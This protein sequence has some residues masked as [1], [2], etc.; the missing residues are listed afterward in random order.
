M[1][2]L[3][4]DSRQTPNVCLIARWLLPRRVPAWISDWP[5][6]TLSRNLY[7]NHSNQT[8]AGMATWFTFLHSDDLLDW[9]KRTFFFGPRVMVLDPEP[10]HLNL[11]LP[12]REE[13][14]TESRWPQGLI[15]GCFLIARDHLF[16]MLWPMRLGLHTIQRVGTDRQPRSESFDLGGRQR[17]EG[18]SL[19][20][21][22]ARMC[23]P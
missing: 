19:D 23:F 15:W 6:P 9:Q 17:A 4:P 22:H 16:T 5:R 11:V 12:R 13:V 10:R 3:F 21:P 8:A 18:D 20:L 7:F 2:A 14:K 1:C